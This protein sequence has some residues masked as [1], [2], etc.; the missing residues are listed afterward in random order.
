MNSSSRTKNTFLNVLGGI[1]VKTSGFFTT[2]ITRTVFLYVLGIEYAGVSS[3]F[4]NVLTVLSFAE[5]GVGTAITYALYK[6]IAENDNKQISKLMNAYRKIYSTIGIV[7]FLVGLCLLPFINNIIKDAPSIKENLRLIYLFYLSNTSV[8]YFLI[9]KSTFLTA[10]Q[11]DHLVSKY[12]VFVSIAKMI[13]ECVALLVFKSFIVY[14]ALSIVFSFTQNLIVAKVAE[15]EYPILKQK[16]KEKL[17]ESEKKG[18]F[19][20]TKALAMYKVSGTVLNGTDS[21]LISSLF[22]T[23]N[24]GILG[25]YNLITGQIY[26]FVMI[27]FSATSASVGNLAA[28]SDK[29]HQYKIF[30]QMLFISFWL[31]CFCVTSLWTLLNP[32]MYV[33]QNGQH[34]FSGYIVALLV[35]EFYIRGMLSP[36]TQFRTSNGLFVQGKYR[37]VIMAIINI[38]TSIVL[39]K[40]IGIAGIFLGTIISRATTQLWYDPWLIY[41][42]VFSVN[43]LHYFKTYFIYAFVTV[44]CCALTSTLLNVVCAQEGIIKILVG[45]VLCIVIPNVAIIALFHK[46]EV[47]AATINIMRNIVSGMLKKNK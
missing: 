33:W 16:S 18:L 30:E 15:R 8:S 38:V 39:A 26:S 4:T 44:I 17:E 37:P 41:K 32:F 28:T 12:S 14:L 9:Y 23:G 47:F 10:V 11:K 29:K 3:V 5:L 19:K 42:K 7:I 2:F 22:G 35:I 43:V 31:Y 40:W 27:L 46:T 21:I 34:M 20:D 36:V 13:V 1:I 25:N 24:A 6:P 45:I